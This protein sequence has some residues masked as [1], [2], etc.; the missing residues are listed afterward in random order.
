VVTVLGGLPEVQQ[1]HAVVLVRRV[2][3]RFDG[4][5]VV[6]HE[7]ILRLPLAGQVAAGQVDH[8]ADV[9]DVVGAHRADVEGL[10]ADA[11]QQLVTDVLDARAVRHPVD[12]VVLVH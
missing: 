12:G 5:L 10:V 3:V 1:A 7:P 4:V 9:V 8:P 11:A 2:P 6:A